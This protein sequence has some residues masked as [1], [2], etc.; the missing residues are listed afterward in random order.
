MTTFVRRLVPTESPAM[1]LIVA[2]PS[3]RITTGRVAPYSFV[4]AGPPNIFGDPSLRLTELVEHRVKRL[5]LT[6]GR[7]LGR[8]ASLRDRLHHHGGFSLSGSALRD[9]V[10]QTSFNAIGNIASEAADVRRQLL[11]HEA[12]NGLQIAGMN[13]WRDVDAERRLDRLNPAQI[14]PG[15]NP[16]DPASDRQRRLA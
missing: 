4:F 1:P 16:V 2:G 10:D 5:G 12:E 11:R 14:E 8:F 13:E 15:S 9:E 7:L 6:L 3:G